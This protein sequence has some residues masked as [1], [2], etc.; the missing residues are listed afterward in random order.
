MTH[1]NDD[2]LYRE[3]E[4]RQIVYTAQIGLLIFKIVHL[5]LYSL[6]RPVLHPSVV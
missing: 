3:I 6:Q 5:S 4:S 2:I 1:D